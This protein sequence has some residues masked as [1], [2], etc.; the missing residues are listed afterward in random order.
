VA[1]SC[2]HGDEPSSSIHSREF[3]WM[4]NHYIFKKYSA[5]F[6]EELVTRTFL[7]NLVYN[8]RTP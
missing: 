8:V 5:P 7:D 4:G 3:D 1:G 2:E 6:Y